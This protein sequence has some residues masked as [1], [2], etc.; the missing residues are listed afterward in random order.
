MNLDEEFEI[1][2]EF[3]KDNANMFPDGVKVLSFRLK[4]TKYFFY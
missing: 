2:K 4:K 3:A 1:I